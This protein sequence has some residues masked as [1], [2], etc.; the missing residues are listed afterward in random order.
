[1][2]RLPRACSLPSLVPAR[3]R[4]FRRRLNLAALRC[5][6]GAELIEIALV[7]PLYFAVVFGLTSFAIVVFAY[8]NA[9]FAS[10]AAVRYA[11]VHS[12]ATMQ[13]CQTADIQNIVY[14]FLWGVPTGGASI[15]SSWSPANTLGSLVTVK[16]TLTY[17]AGLPYVGLGGLKATAMAN[18]YIVH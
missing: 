13:P 5:D 2:A 16:V 10:K 3:I 11:V 18:G 12:T 6:G 1:M 7:L 8:C 15:S 17:S 4:F 14:P 9:T